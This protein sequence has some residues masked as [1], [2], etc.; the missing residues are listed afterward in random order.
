MNNPLYRGRPGASIGSPLIFPITRNPVIALSPPT[1]PLL[2]SATNLYHRRAPAFPTNALHLDQRGNLPEGEMR[3][4]LVN[5]RLLAPY[6][7]R[8]LVLLT[9]KPETNQFISPSIAFENAI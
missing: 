4:T 9:M 5:L 3:S 1:L 8:F 7:L 6:L 2:P